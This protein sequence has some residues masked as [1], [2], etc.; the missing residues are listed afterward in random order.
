VAE[1]AQ[2][3]KGMVLKKKFVLPTKSW[4]FNFF[5]FKKNKIA[6]GFV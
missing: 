2:G 3:L 5:Y 4:F 6:H 1:I